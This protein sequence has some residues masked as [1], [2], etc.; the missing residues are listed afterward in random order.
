MKKIVLILSLVLAFFSSKGQSFNSFVSPDTITNWQEGQQV[1]IQFGNLNSGVDVLIEL[2]L[3]G[4][5]S[6]NSTIT[7]LVNQS[8]G[9]IDVPWTVPPGSAT[10]SAVLR[11]SN[12]ANPLNDNIISSSFRISISPPPSFPPTVLG[13]NPNS[14]FEGDLFEIQGDGFINDINV[15]MGITPIANYTVVSPFSILA[16]VPNGIG[17]G[18]FSIIVTN[19]DGPSAPTVSFQVD[20]N[21]ALT[22]I[23]LTADDITAN[24][25]QTQLNYFPVPSNANISNISWVVSDPSLAY[26]ADDGFFYLRPINNGIVTVTGIFSNALSTVSSSVVVNITN[27]DQVTALQIENIQSTNATTVNSTLDFFSIVFPSTAFDGVTWSSSNNTVGTIDGDGFFSALSVGVTT[28]TANSIQNPSIFAEFEVTVGNAIPNPNVTLISVIG[29]TFRA[30]DVVNPMLV[31]YE[32]DGP[33]NPNNL[34]NVLLSDEFGSYD[35]PTTIATFPTGSQSGYIPC[36]I[37][38]NVKDGN[39][40]RVTMN[41]SFITNANSLDNGLDITILPSLPMLM[42]D[43]PF[44]PLG[45][46]VTLSGD[47]GM[48]L[49]LIDSVKFSSGLEKVY[50]PFEYLPGGVVLTTITGNINFSLGNFS[51]Y[52]SNKRAM[53]EYNGSFNIFDINIKPSSLTIINES[54]YPIENIGDFTFFYPNYLPQTYIDT[55]GPLG[56]QWRVEPAEFATIDEYGILTA[57]AIGETVTITA[58]S[59][60]HP[61]VSGSLTFFLGPNN[62]EDLPVEAIFFKEKYL[63]IDKDKDTLNLSVDFLP[64]NTKNRELAWFISPDSIATVDQFGVVRPKQDG[65]VEVVAQS[66]NN[67]NLTDTA[68]VFIYNQFISV[69]GFTFGLESNELTALEGFVQLLPKFTPWNATNQN[70]E[71]SVN[72]NNPSLVEIDTTFQLVYLVGNTSEIITITGRSREKPNFT[73]TLTLKVIGSFVEIQTPIKNEVKDSLGRPNPCEGKLELAIDSTA[74][75]GFQWY[76][77]DLLIVGAKSHKYKPLIPGNYKVRAL[78]TD[79]VEFPDFKVQLLSFVKPTIKLDSLEVLENDETVKRPFLIAS[80]ASAYQWYL[81]NRIINGAVNDTLPVRLRGRYFVAITDSNK[82]MARSD[83][84]KYNSPSAR[85]LAES[86]LRYDA[87]SISD[88]FSEAPKPSFEKA[89]VYPNPTTGKI[90]IKTSIESSGVASLDIFNSFGAK[91]FHQSISTAKDGQIFEE[92]DLSNMP[93]GI[94]LLNIQ[95]GAK[96]INK[97]LILK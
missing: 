90:Y 13:V 29:T 46:V 32:L 57:L 75:R 54:T 82:C 74:Y 3:D 66:R 55:L 14:G 70:V 81:E 35:F 30:G 78:G 63:V 95:S 77:N 45:T 41:G 21:I 11:A 60:N 73:N 12:I 94:Y 88:Y 65:F 92:V 89:E 58:T 19:L 76:L 49:P 38:P 56:T 24:G 96:T 91:V 86:G 6:F 16:I 68:Y 15:E 37:P 23:S 40:Y 72:A 27:Q 1:N 42:V 53:I 28:V 5:V 48:S 61:T 84:F 31:Y 17:T 62:L 9:F 25:D 10:I 59:V 79:V 4:G 50:L 22:S 26:V 47:G 43:P 33:A 18:L 67:P 97:K 85:T 51:L 93:L 2:S 36:F 20:G 80:N 69:T 8:S 44:G 83:T 64:A 7:S 87:Y 71:W 39:L 34:I 52:D